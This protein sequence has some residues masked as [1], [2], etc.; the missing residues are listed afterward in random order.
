MHAEGGFPPMLFDLENDPDEFHDLGR[1][2]DYQDQVSECYDKLFDWAIRCSQ[3]T[4]MSKAE[5]LAKRGSS[6]R[7]GIVLGL[8]D[9]ETADKE[10]TVKY[11]GRARQNHLK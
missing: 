10:L 8:I 9:E 11:T 6:R 3:R 1:H 2:P 7:K 5:L 4:S